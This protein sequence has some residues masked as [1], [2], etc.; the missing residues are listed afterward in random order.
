VRPD[1]PRRER[2]HHALDREARLLEQTVALAPE[3]WWSLFFP[4]WEAA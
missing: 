3:Q 2:L 1:A 4:I